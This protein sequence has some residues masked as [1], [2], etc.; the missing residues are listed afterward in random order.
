M[1]LTTA[2][3]ERIDHGPVVG[4]EPEDRGLLRALGFR[5]RSRS[6]GRRIR[7]ISCLA[8]PHR[9]ALGEIDR[10]TGQSPTSRSRR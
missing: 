3:A 7:P 10:L 6:A 9:Q 8:A 1:A 5:D 2:S 4:L